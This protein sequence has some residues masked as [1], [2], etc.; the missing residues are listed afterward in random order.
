MNGK[1]ILGAF[2]FLLVL[3]ITVM[4]GGVILSDTINQETTVFDNQHRA[5][6]IRDRLYNLTGKSI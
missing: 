1:D 6:M 3:S 5:C 4:I 2:I